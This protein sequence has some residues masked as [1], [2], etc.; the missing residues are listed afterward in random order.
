MTEVAVNLLTFEDIDALED[1]DGVRYELWDGQPVAM[2]SGTRAHN[3][4]ALG[5]RDVLRRQLPRQRDVFV[6]DM[7]LRFSSSQTKHNQTYPDVMVVCNAERGAYQETPIIVAEVLSE[8][9]VSRD[10]QRKFKMY[11]GM[12]SVAAYLIL[13]QTAIEIE[14][15]QRVNE[16]MEEVYRGENAVIELAQ[17]SLEIPLRQVYDEVWELLS[18]PG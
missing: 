14:V 15:Y 10:R 9:S 13:S 1:R 17:L 8:S 5:L 2:T 16:W 18:G 11:Q 12:E 3:L 4:V 7:A 6:A